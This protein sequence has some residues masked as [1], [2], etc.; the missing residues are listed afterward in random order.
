MKTI[1]SR[2]RALCAKKSMYVRRPASVC[3]TK[4]DFKRGS[5]ENRLLKGQ[6]ARKKENSAAAPT[7]YKT[8]TQFSA[9][10]AL[11]GIGTPSPCAPL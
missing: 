11:G 2:N 8:E 5:L 9:L 10:R 1:P 6:T 4:L 3:S 7:Q